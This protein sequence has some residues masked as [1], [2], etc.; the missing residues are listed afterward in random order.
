MASLLAAMAISLS[1][2]ECH[3]AA[4]DFSRP[5]LSHIWQQE[6][7][8]PAP[9]ATKATTLG[10]SKSTDPP[11][12]A[13]VRVIVPENGATSYGSGTLIDLRDRFGLV[14]TNWHVVRDAKGMVDVVFPGG[15]KSKARALKVDP[16]W[17]LAALVIWRPPVEPVSIA[18]IAPQPGD[19]LTICGYGQGSYR[20]A[21]GRCT[22]YY[23]PRLDFP[24]HMVELD[25]E[26]RQGDSGGPIFNSQGELAGVLF[27]AGEGTT[28][29][30][31]GG[32][33]DSFLSSLAPDIGQPSDRL[34]AANDPLPSD[35]G[36]IC[37]Q[38]GICVP[39]EDAEP[40]RIVDTEPSATQSVDHGS[41]PPQSPENL[42]SMW[43]E[44]TVASEVKKSSEISQP[45]Q[46]KIAQWQSISGQGSFEQMKTVLA[47]IG[48]VSIAVLILRA[49]R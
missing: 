8:L 5:Q 39:R 29:G 38:N 6:F 19:L 20:S 7:S 36:Q 31:F 43:P 9:D 37:C 10:Y 32:R 3:G 22:Q 23:A 47:A 21:T 45:A 27:G 40:P 14:I 15:F 41:S 35:C 18:S 1:T 12:P 44:E 30:S 25:V 26:A 11:H 48:L 28:L 49:A 33:V 13:V 2:L 34:L 42:A 46:A 4:A 17:D 24:R 16:D